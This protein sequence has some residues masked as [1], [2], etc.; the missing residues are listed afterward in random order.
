MQV[1]KHD[2]RRRLTFEFTGL[3]GFSR[4]SGGMMGWALHLASLTYSTQLCGLINNLI[5]GDQMTATIRCNVLQT[6]FL[7]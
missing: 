2:G 4:R 1:K 3:R 5:H 7:F 6:L